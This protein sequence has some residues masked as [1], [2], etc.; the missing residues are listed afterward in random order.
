MCSALQNILVLTT[1]TGTGNM[2]WEEP[3]PIYV[4]IPVTP[5][6][7]PLLIDAMKRNIGVWISID[8]FRYATNI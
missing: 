3:C 7:V 6:C 8:V 2:M 5:C 4:T 1:F